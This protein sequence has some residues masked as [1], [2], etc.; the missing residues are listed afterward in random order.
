MF[1]LNNY[2]SIFTPPFLFFSKSNFT[3][4]LEHGGKYKLQKLVVQITQYWCNEG[5]SLLAINL[6]QVWQ[7]IWTCE[8]EHW[9]PS[10]GWSH[11]RHF[12]PEVSSSEA[13]RSEFFLATLPLEFFVPLAGGS[14]ATFDLTWSFLPWIFYWISMGSWP[15]IFFF[16]AYYYSLSDLFY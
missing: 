4:D 2:A 9:N 8:D 5:S 12:F 10:L 7:G 15:K 16:L 1:P 13:E 6:P 11:Y 3:P 14:T